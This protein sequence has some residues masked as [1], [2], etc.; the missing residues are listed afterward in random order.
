MCGAFTLFKQQMHDQSDSAAQVSTEYGDFKGK[1]LQTLVLV[2]D[3]F[4]RMKC[5]IQEIK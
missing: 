4:V 5:R 1:H 2:E 3:R